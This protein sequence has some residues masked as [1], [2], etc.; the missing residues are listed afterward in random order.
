MPRFIASGPDIPER[1]LWAHEEGRVVFFCGAGISYPAGLP[2]FKGLVDQMYVKLGTTQ[3]PIEEQAYRNSQYV[4]TLG[5]LERRYPGQRLAVRTVLA[6]VLKPKWRKEGATTTH[7][8]LLR[9]ATDRK[10]K[11]RLVTTNFDRIFQ[12]LMMQ[13]RPAIPGYEALL[14]PIPKPT[15]WHGVVHLHGL[16]PDLP[17]EIALNRLVLSSGDFGLAYLTERWAARFVSEL[18]RY[19]TVCFVGYSIND[20]VLRYMMDALA[21]DSMLGENRPEAFALG[22]FNNGGQSQAMLEWEAKGVVPLLYEVPSGTQD[23]SGLHLTLK[24]W[25]DTYRDGVRGKEMIVAQ[26]ASTPPLT[27]SRLDYAVGRVL[28]ALTDGLAAKHFA[29]LNPVPPLKWLEP[30]GAEQFTHDDLPRFGVMPKR[31][32]DNKLTFSAIRRPPPYTL[33]PQMSLVDT[34]TSESAWDEVMFQLARWLTRHMDDPDLVLW[35]AKQ[36]GQL[37]NHFARHVQQRLMDLDRL[38]HDSNQEELDRIRAAAPKAIPSPLMRVIWRLILSGRLE[39]YAHRYD[40]YDWLRRFNQDGL[41]PTL[42]LEL[43]ETLTPRVAL[44]KPF[45]WKEEPEDSH[46]IKNINDLVEW[47]IVLSAGHVHSTL[48]DMQKLP[49]WSLALP[50]LL[51]EFSMLLRDTLDLMREL[52]GAQDKSDLSYLH[53]PSISAHSQNNDFRD[54]TALIDLARDAWMA[55]AQ[56]DPDQAQRTAAWWWQTPYPLFKRLA[57]LQLLTVM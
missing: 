49:S 48:R 32:R 40:L 41:T 33:A 18:F 31:E 36:G 10:G 16:L 21:V 1:L 4:A 12:R 44:R 43:R 5:L 22:S 47:E 38:I 15:R 42:R 57:F 35:L 2:D 24:E 25:A 56:N 20:P 8:A 28:W 53:H 34:G 9:L 37:H 3:D 27:S 14:L 46:E 50:E 39:S 26:H 7:E 45:R 55:T 51:Q 13:C 54:W 52:G 6:E 29:D 19:Y 11:V 17:D 30:L 23:H